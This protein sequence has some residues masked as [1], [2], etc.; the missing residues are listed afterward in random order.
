MKETEL[1]EII[2]QTENNEMMG[3]MSIKSGNKHI[4]I[5][6]IVIHEY[7]YARYG[8][9]LGGI[10]IFLGC[11]LCLNHFVGT[12]SWTAKIL[13]AE[14][15]ISDAAP[16]VVLFIVGLFIIMITKPKVEIG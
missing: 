5:P 10:C 1:K 9:I 12:T 16:G 7:K 6:D 8:L 14:S 4:P 13:G 2:K 3:S 11:L 15:R